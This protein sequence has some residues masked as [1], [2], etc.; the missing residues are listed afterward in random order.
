M[1]CAGIVIRD[2][3]G[4]VVGYTSVVTTHIP[5]AFAAEALA[6]YHAIRLG[7]ELGLQEGLIGQFHLC[8]FLHVPHE[9]NSVAHLLATKGLRGEGRVIQRRGGSQ[10][11]LFWPWRRI[12]AVFS[13]T[14]GQDSGSLCVSG[15]LFF[16]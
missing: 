16:Q 4:S 1:T 5:S 6:C 11:S 9:G 3:L 14:L 2:N 13:L 7:L 8:R 10:S 12:D 15:S